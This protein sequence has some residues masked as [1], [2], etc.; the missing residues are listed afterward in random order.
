MHSDD[1]LRANDTSMFFVSLEGRSACCKFACLP[2]APS[3]RWRQG[4]LLDVKT[5]DVVHPLLY[6]RLVVVV[7]LSATSCIL[8]SLVFLWWSSCCWR[9]CASPWW[10]GALVC[11]Q[12]LSPRCCGGRPRRVLFSSGQCVFRRHCFVAV[13]VGRAWSG[14]AALHTGWVGEGVDILWAPFLPF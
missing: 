14:S 2:A 8:F 7:L 9:C 1:A 13:I 10:C 12:L 3:S 4:G 11:G 6:R 5:V